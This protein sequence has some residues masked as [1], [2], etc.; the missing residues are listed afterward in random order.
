M[1]HKQEKKVNIMAFDHIK[2]VTG[3]FMDYCVHYDILMIHS[4]D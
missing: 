4:L 1:P 2:K 3:A